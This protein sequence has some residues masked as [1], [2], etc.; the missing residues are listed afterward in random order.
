[1]SNTT[2]ANVEV[3]VTEQ[4][5][6]P[7]TPT[8]G[9]VYHPTLGIIGN[10]RTMLWQPDGCTKAE[11]LA[12][13]VTLFPDRD[14]YGMSVT[15][16]I[17]LGRLQKKWGKIVSQKVDGRGRVY[18]FATTLNVFPS[19]ALPGAPEVPEVDMTETELTAEIAET[20]IEAE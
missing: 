1:M 8:L 2:V 11:V 14:P 10:L 20:L 17:Q 7:V 9:V 5:E 18:G 15:V 4:V 3:E 19:A 6:A 13:L 12:T 16:Q